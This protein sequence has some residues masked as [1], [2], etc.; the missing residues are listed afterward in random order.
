[1]S[2]PTHHYWGVPID[3]HSDWHW[4][5][6]AKGARSEGEI[7]STF[8]RGLCWQLD[9]PCPRRP[10]FPSWPWSGWIGPLADA[11]WRVDDE[12]GDRQVKIWLQR[13]NGEYERLSESVVGT[14]CQRGPP[15]TG[16]T[17]VLRIEAW[18]I[19]TTLTYLS[20]GLNGA[21]VKLRGWIRHPRYFV[22]VEALGAGGT[23][24]AHYDGLSCF[25]YK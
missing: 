12:L 13:T 7:D 18:V 14:I 20:H 4:D 2:I 6:A 16:Y 21:I 17:P 19:G 11:N 25:R 23:F 5:W 22:S 24:T 1:M 15:Y 9:M 3:Y 10:D 8:A